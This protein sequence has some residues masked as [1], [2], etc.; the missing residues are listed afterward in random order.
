MEDGIALETHTAYHSILD[1]PRFIEQ[2]Y[3]AEIVESAQFITERT[4]VPVCALFTPFGS[5]YDQETDT[6]N[7]HVVAACEEAG[8]R[9]VVGIAGGRAP[10]PTAIPSGEVIYVGRVGPGLTNDADG[11]R[12]EIEHW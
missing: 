8:I 2:D 9:F 6:I 4:G 5:G 7:P 1:N 11:A 10:I 3:R 12:Y